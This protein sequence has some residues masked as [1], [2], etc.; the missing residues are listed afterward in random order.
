VTVLDDAAVS[1]FA[2]DGFVRLEHAFSRELAHAG[3]AVLWRL[4]GCDP[5]DASTWRQPMVRIGGL[6]DPAFREAANTPR[7]RAALD[8]LFGAERYQPLQGLGPFPIRFPSQA[9]PGDTGWHVDACLPGDEPADFPSHRVNA[10]SSGRVALLWFLFSDVCERAAPTR[11]RVGSQREVARVLAPFG[12]RGLSRMEL[13]QRLESTTSCPVAHA[14]GDAGTVYIC[15][16]LLVHA[17]QPHRGWTPRFLAQPP[18]LP[19]A[20]GQNAP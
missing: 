9:D 14:T 7:L 1:A 4:S 17:A 8:Q 6:G 15:H 12:E 10:G 19:R 3:R 13:A 20:A 5:S 16:P 2:E 11:I 18:L